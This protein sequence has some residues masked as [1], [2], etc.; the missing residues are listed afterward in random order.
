MSE[1]LKAA[2]KRGALIAAANW[3]VTL[4]QAI[5]DSLFKLLI[6]APVVGG[7]FLVALVIGAEP[8]DLFTLEWRDMITTIVG[9]LL[10]NPLV[11]TAFL[12]AL[13]V[14]VVGGSVLVFLVKGGTVT[15]L[16]IGDHYAGPIE[17][18]P[19][20]LQAV[21]RASRFS[22]E[23]FIAAS[24]R[25]FPRYV[26]LGFALMTVYLLSGAAYLFIVLTSQIGS[27]WGLAALLTT[28]FVAWITIINLVYLL[29]QI[30]IAAD[31][32][33]VASAIARVMAFVRAETTRVLATFAVV[34]AIVICATGASVLATTAL[35]L[36]SFVPF[37]GL[38]VL[39][40]QLAA[41]LLRSLVFQYIGL[42]SIGAYLKLY[43]SF[44][45]TVAARPARA[46]APLPSSAS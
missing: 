33:S 5:A 11:L 30:V 13:G 39:P 34:L 37:F 16:V 2:L 24:S 15:T 10:A 1:L 36:I 45:N 26:R 22:A 3:Q 32:C 42:T 7:V 29:L 41:W 14:V 43:R 25:L 8:K 23:N 46:M 35:G 40:L 20:H 9:A 44:S 12:L 21:A 18:P 27:R 6:A 28:A 4:I 17:Q 38:A 31:D 19:L